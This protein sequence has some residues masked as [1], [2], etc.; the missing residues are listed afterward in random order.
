MAVLTICILLIVL[1]AIQELLHRVDQF[2]SCG[3]LLGDG[4]GCVGLLG[5]PD[6]DALLGL[7]PGTVYAHLLGGHILSLPSSHCV[8]T[9]CRDIVS[10]CQG[11]SIS[12]ALE[13]LLLCQPIEKEDGAVRRDAQ[14]LGDFLRCSCVVLP[15][16]LKDSLLYPV[17]P[18]IEEHPHLRC[19]VESYRPSGNVLDKVA[20]QQA[21]KSGQMSKSLSEDL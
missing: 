20:S 8:A 3:C 21:L 7:K 4:P 12:S 1:I 15:N 11:N 5:Q 17:H 18:L 16:E 6:A 13:L 2:Q 10:R 19:A 9:L 14:T